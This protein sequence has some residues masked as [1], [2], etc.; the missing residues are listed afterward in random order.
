MAAAAGLGAVSSAGAQGTTRVVT[1]PGTTTRV[2]TTRSGDQII[3]V[4]VNE[5]PV[6][7]EQEQ[8]PMMMGGR[9]LVPLRGV[10]EKL[11]GEVKWE[12]TT[13]VITGAHAGQNKQFRL[14]VGS[15]EALV[16]GENV[17]LD[18]PP[19]VANGTTYVPLRFVSKRWARR[20]AGTT[21]AAPSSSPPPKAQLPL[22]KR[23]KTAGPTEN[24][25][26]VGQNPTAFLLPV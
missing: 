7:F 16:N 8:R 6:T 5:Q 24:K 22:E 12:P 25:K 19:R 17:T 4:T 2:T 26:A 15:R 20:C 23:R 11:G 13:R 14:R 21:P 9:V 18:A 1:P 10:I 3:T